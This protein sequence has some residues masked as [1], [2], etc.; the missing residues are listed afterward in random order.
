MKEQEM[1]ERLMLCETLLRE[2]EKL[3]HHALWVNHVDGHKAL[4]LETKIKE[5]LDVDWGADHESKET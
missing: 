2:A 3:L 5:L 1:I 4:A